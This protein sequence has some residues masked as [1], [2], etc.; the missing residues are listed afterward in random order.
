MS[1]KKK[2]VSGD[3]MNYLEVMLLEDMNDEIEE[4]VYTDIKWW[5]K[6]KKSEYEYVVERMN[7]YYE[8]N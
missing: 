4:K 8:N 6:C 1:I 2:T 5:G 3:V 7:E